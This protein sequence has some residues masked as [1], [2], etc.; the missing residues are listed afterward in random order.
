MI[1]Q[2]EVKIVQ[3]RSMFCIE[4][5]FHYHM[6]MSYEYVHAYIIFIFKPQHLELDNSN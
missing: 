4:Q 5:C 1:K 2:F 3:W 6:N